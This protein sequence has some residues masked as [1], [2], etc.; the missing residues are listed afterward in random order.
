MERRGPGG[1]RGGRLPRTA[2]GRD[3]VRG[4][5]PRGVHGLP[6]RAAD[7]HARRGPEPADRMA[8]ERLL[9]RLH[10]GGRSRRG[11]P[12]RRR[13]ELPLA[14]VHRHRDRPRPRSGRRAR[15]DP[16]RAAG[17]RAPHASRAGDGCGD[18]S[19]PGRGARAPAV[20]LRGADGDRR[21]PAR[22]LSRRRSTVGQPLVGRAALR[23]PR[24]ESARRQGPVRQA[25]RPARDT[26]RHDRAR[27]GRGGVRR[28]GE[29][30]GR[31]RPGH[32]GLRRGARA[33]RGHDR[34]L[35]RGRRAADRRVAR[36]RADPLPP[37]ARAPRAPA[38]RA[39]G[40]QP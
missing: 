21:R 1:D 5:R 25:L 27:R 32:P 8:R 4:H 31:L 22:R 10:P 13:A 18:R 11:D 28:P 17:G 6:G 26:D 40:Q 29:R 37:R 14:R 38:G 12:R 35:R 33:A 20:A 34:V 39:G 19:R 7:G 36:C 3:T 23:V 2:V 16:R 24:A 30:G 15:R 9:P